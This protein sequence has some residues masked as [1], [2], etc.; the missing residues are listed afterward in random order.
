M[1]SYRVDRLPH[2]H[3]APLGRGRMRA[4]PEDFQVHEELGIVPDGGGEHALVHIEKRGLNTEWVARALARLAGVRPVDVGYA[5]LKD[6]QAVT[7][8]WFSVNL[9]GRP[10]PDWEALAG[11]EL[12]VLAAV[13]HGRKLR[14]GVLRGNRFVLRLRAVDAGEGAVDERLTRVGEQGVPNYFGEQRFGREAGNLD[15]ALQL[16]RGTLRVKPHQ[17]GLYLSAARALLFNAVLARRVLDGNWARPLPGEAVMLEGTHSFFVAEEPDATLERRVLEWDLHPTGPLWGRGEP[18][19]RGEAQ[20]LEHAVLAEFGPWCE[21]L[22]RFGLGQERRALR[23]RP[24]AL[25]WSQEGDTLE[26]RF[27]LPPG[28]YATTVLRE[29]LDLA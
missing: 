1:S 22:E 17:R 26:L 8:Q 24:A 10:E 16:F 28:A 20:G 19:P 3:G 25:E 18:L 5:G 12:A 14:R 29:V 11:P 4:T 6:R 2:A 13:R 21:G 23:V 15:Q 7:R 27:G 9:A